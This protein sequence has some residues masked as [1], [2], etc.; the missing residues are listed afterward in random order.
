[1]ACNLKSE[2]KERTEKKGHDAMGVARGVVG[3]EFSHFFFSIL[4]TKQQEVK[5]IY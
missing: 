4:L 5:L 3:C 1:M 2:E